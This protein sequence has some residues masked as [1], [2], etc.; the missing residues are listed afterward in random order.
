MLDVHVLTL[1]DTPPEWVAQRRASIDA[2]VAAAGYPVF[3]H[4]VPGIVGHLGEARRA[5]YSVGVQ[6]YAT[7]V[8]HD[9]YLPVDAFVMLAPLLGVVDAITTGETLLNEAGETCDMSLAKH[10]LAVF[11]RTAMAA[12]QYDRFKHFPDQFLLAKL[13]A[14]HI[15]R[16]G[17][18]HRIYMDSLSRRQRHAHASEAAEEMEYV[19]DPSLFAVEAM[20]IPNLEALVNG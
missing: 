10:H 20:P 4:E 11:R 7:H 1:I 2:A 3:I 13:P 6:P 5:G 15:P 19:R 9:D 17:Y 18:V 14:T 12:I 16:C 8:D